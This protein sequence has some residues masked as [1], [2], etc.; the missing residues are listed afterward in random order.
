MIDQGPNGPFTIEQ[1]DQSGATVLVLT[2]E[3]D[4]HSSRALAERIEGL[5]QQGQRSVAVDLADVGFVDS[6]GLRVLI[7]AH[8]EFE[9][10]NGS[11]RLRGASPAFSRLVEIT[12]LSDLFVF[13]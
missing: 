7:R 13:E 9:D 5:L 1:R 3:L 8:R 11:F 2:G 4:A 12:G 10:G 6:S